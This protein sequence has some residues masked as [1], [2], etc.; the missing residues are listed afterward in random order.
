[1]STGLL[2]S[3]CWQGFSRFKCL[4]VTG[5]RYDHRLVTESMNEK[6]DPGYSG[7]IG[8]HAGTARFGGGARGEQTH[9]PWPHQVATRARNPRNTERRAPA[10]CGIDIMPPNLEETLLSETGGECASACPLPLPIV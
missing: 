1:M 10:A 6:T 5:R 2:T 3:A 7:N 9:T 8:V 4:T